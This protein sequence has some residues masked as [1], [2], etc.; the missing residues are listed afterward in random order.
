[1]SQKIQLDDKEYDFADLS[2]QGRA[3]ALLLQF[4]NSRVSELRNMHAL[5]QRARN[6]YLDSLKK[7]M[8]SDKAGFLLEED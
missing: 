4:A 8:L 5:L 2:D 6:S 1:M 7:E 3:T